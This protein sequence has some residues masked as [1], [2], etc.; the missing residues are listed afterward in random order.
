V[1]APSRVAPGPPVFY[2]WVVLMASVAII[3]VG[4]GTIFSL[5]VF[6]RPLEEDFGWT[7]SLIS[8]VAL[9]NWVIF[10]VGSFI[11]G[12]IS[13]RIGARRVVA[14]GAALLG[15]ALVASSQIRTAAQ[16]YV[17]FGVI[18]AL[19][20]SAFYVPLS[21]TATRWFAARR[22]LAMGIISSGMGLGILV[23]PPT[24]RALITALGW[25]AAFAAFG[26]LTWIVGGVALR[27]LVN[28]P[29]DR[30]LQGYGAEIQPVGPRPAPAGG[31]L[32]AAA[33]LRHPAFWGVAL[34][35]FGCC[36]AHSGPIFHMV[37]HAM[38]LGVTKMAAASM[39]GLSGG[40]SIAGRLSSGVLADRF[41]ARPALVG[42][43][44]I[45]ALVLS[46]Y[47]YAG[48]AVSLFVVALFFGV[49]YGGAMP[50][51]ALVAREF[52]G[53][54][55]VG[56]TFGGIFFISCLG[57]GLGAYGGGFLYDHLGT[58]WSLHLASTLVAAGAVAVA[59]ALRP[60]PVRV[61]AL[62]PSV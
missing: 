36:A 55:V 7:R 43:L 29:E 18:G 14:V 58:Y 12:V 40:T 48:A 57:M 24:A 46:F 34:V 37:A 54:R 13:D 52:F 35:H 45:Q 4:T 5:A 30:G 22:G 21:A 38:D 9:V 39:L 1:T 41:G 11:A 61:A 44:A 19:G 2:G 8:G 51:Y 16:L 32:T 49:A 20:A 3:A 53:E 23:V 56:T 47:L 15:A 26:G 33:V 60:P 17:A 50:L 25:R 31:D 6:L 42:M 10:G 59:M 28:R 62:A 27:Y